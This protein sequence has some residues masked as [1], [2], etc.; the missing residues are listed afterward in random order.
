MTREKDRVSVMSCMTE[1]GCSISQHYA[2]PIDSTISIHIFQT[3]TK[4]IN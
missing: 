1:C 2:Q 3:K 4:T